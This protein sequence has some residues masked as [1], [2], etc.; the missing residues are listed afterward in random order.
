MGANEPIFTNKAGEFC[1]T[2]DY[3]YVSQPI[4]VVS[5]LKMPYDKECIERDFHLRKETDQYIEG[6]WAEYRSFTAWYRHSVND[7]RQCK[8]VKR[9]LLLLRGF[10][11]QSAERSTSAIMALLMQYICTEEEWRQQVVTQDHFASQQSLWRM[12]RMRQRQSH[13]LESTCFAAW[14]YP[15]MPNRKDPSDHLALCCDLLIYPAVSA[16]QEEED[17]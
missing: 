9:N 3:I 10:L 16:E 8:G 14:N 7:I 4:E 15:Q 12:I 6:R 5:I 11:G 2:I 13:L 17:E 1:D